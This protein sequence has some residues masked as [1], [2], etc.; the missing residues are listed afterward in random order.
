LS[1]QAKRP[2]R[3]RPGRRTIPMVAESPVPFSFLLKSPGTLSFPRGILAHSDKNAMTANA[4]N[5]GLDRDRGKRSPQGQPLLGVVLPPV[6]VLAED[7]HGGLSLQN[8]K[9]TMRE[10]PPAGG[11]MGESA[12]IKKRWEGGFPA[13][14]DT[15]LAGL[16]GMK[17]L[18]VSSP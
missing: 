8:P 9:P 18:L 7:R 11:D 15:T 12:R 4:G 14:L 5:C 1:I 3:F 2:A 13:S 17:G 10:S 16:L 6:V